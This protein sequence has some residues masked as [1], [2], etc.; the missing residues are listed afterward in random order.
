[1]FSVCVII[2][3]YKT[4]LGEGKLAKIS[5]T[6]V[7]K[8]R[9]RIRVLTVLACLLIFAFAAWQIIIKNPFGTRAAS[10]CTGGVCTIDEIGT[11]AP[12]EAGE[13]F[14]SQGIT[15]DYTNKRAISCSGSQTSI[16]SGDAIV[17]TSG[18]TVT[19]YFEN[20]N[21]KNLTIQSGA[22]VTHEG[23]DSADLPEKI[24]AKKVYIKAA[25][26]I[27]I[28]DGAK[29]NVDGKGYNGAQTS[30]THTDGYPD[31]ANGGGHGGYGYD[32]S[33]SKFA[34]GGGGS[35]SVATGGVA[36]S[37]DSSTGTT[38]TSY[39]SKLMIGSLLAPDLNH[40]A[41]GGGTCFQD[42]TKDCSGGGSGGGYIHL[43]APKIEIFPTAAVSANGLQPN[44]PISKLPAGGGA[45]GT[46]EIIGT[47]SYWPDF[48]A[49]GSDIVTKAGVSVTA[50]NKGNNGIVSTDRLSG[51]LSIGT[52]FT[53]L[54]GAAASTN[55]SSYITAGGGGGAGGKVTL[56]GTYSALC[57]LNANSPKDANGHYYIPAACE[58][59][60]VVI[61]GDITVFTDSVKVLNN[62][63]IE[64]R[65]LCVSAAEPNCDSHR[66]FKSLTLEEKAIL[67][68]DAVTIPELISDDSNSNKSLAEET[69]GT[70]RW[71]KVDIETVGD[72]IIKDTSSINVS[73]KGYPGGVFC[74]VS[75]SD[76]CTGG[77]S[78]TAN[79]RL[80]YGPGG[81][82]GGVLPQVLPMPYC[83]YGASYGSFGTYKNDC[84]T[85]L[86]SGI[87]KYGSSDLT[88]P[89]SFEFGSGGGGLKLPVGSNSSDSGGAGGGR[90]K[91][92]VG[93]TFNLSSANII[94]ANGGSSTCFGT[95]PASCGGGG[96][97]G[98][99]LVKAKHFSITDIGTALSIGVGQPNN[100]L[101]AQP[102]SVL[103][104]VYL[105][106]YFQA[107]GG[108][109]GVS[110]SSQG[111]GGG[112]G[113][114]M[115][116]KLVNDSVPTVKKTL[117]PVA[118]DGSAAD[119]DPYTLQK[120]DTIKISLE[121]YGVNEIVD[122]KDTWLSVDA[123]AD[124]SCSY[125]A[126]TGSVNSSDWDMI[127][128]PVV[129]NDAG[130]SLALDQTMK[131][132][133]GKIMISYQCK[134]Q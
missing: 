70:G 112:G 81:G 103:S 15:L 6:G 83:A 63:P 106:I 45:G 98:S 78:T 46:I 133:D 113:R 58:G 5:I 99:I 51:A 122:F 36:S 68:H 25:E 109:G 67:T 59:K 121:V 55:W 10:N 62:I 129:R 132:T 57:Q 130:Y 39:P 17:M 44:S 3:K 21:I 41:S 79:N 75:G 115:V 82:Y 124:E 76:A 50:A 14:C 72:L 102:G 32:Q 66:R 94:S 13:M 123:D 34:W 18:A 93:G 1:M 26:F 77:T 40:G 111:G 101:T 35:S 120:N 52:M 53:A 90:I 28:E 8:T 48:T 84:I 117:T 127:P 19:T 38:A 71:K 11:L 107:K 105:P 23:L 119:F 110:G 27:R 126:G 65:A 88:S 22:T 92:I 96:S 118:R 73:G 108:D 33:V 80:G 43:E 56:T 29:I 100:P 2:N 24:D 31:Y 69:T 74:N 134:V 95:T 64:S 128:Q 20:N 47:V 125:L 97:G 116:K 61:S 114:I 104:D 16:S 4:Y 37:F 49:V 54:G 89:N 86:D 7:L 91:L 9:R 30:L 131:D 85:L 60:D 87:P 42:G 12:T